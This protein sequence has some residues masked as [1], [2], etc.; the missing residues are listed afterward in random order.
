MRGER[1]LM[2][3]LKLQYFGHQMWRTDS[4]EKAL[5]LGK[6]EGK[7][8]GWQR[9]RWLASPTQWRWIWTNSGWVEDRGAWCAAVHEVTKIRTW[10]RNWITTIQPQYMLVALVYEVVILYFLLIS[11][12]SFMLTWKQ[13]VEPEE[14][15]KELIHFSINICLK[16][17]RHRLWFCFLVLIPFFKVSRVNNS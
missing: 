6:V 8:R 5:M 12:L 3:K 13:C 4:F 14:R 11:E 2:L 7:R 1:E 16:Y 10:L 15:M 9:M 17:P